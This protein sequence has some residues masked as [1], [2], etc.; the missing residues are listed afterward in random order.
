MINKNWRT[1]GRTWMMTIGIRQNFGWGLNMQK[2]NKDGLKIWTQA[3]FL[4]P[5]LKTPFPWFPRA[6]WRKVKFHDYS[7]FYITVRTLVR[8]TVQSF[9][10]LASDRPDMLGKNRGRSGKIPTSR[11][12]AKTK[13]P[14]GLEQS[15]PQKKKSSGCSL[16]NINLAR[17]SSLTLTLLHKI[18]S[19]CVSL[20]NIWNVFS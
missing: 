13:I 16:K 5:C 6:F 10:I 8:G 11:G 12:R 3:V 19:M 1:D 20:S 4:F 2:T 17:E 18:C 7:R 9:P 14:T 15:S